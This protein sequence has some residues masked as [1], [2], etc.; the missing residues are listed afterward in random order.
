[1]KAV[2]HP[3]VGTLPDFGN[4][5]GDIDKYD[6]VEKMLPF[7]KGV[8][9][10]STKFEKNGN[11]ANIDY[12]RMMKLVADAGYEGYVGIE[13]SGPIESEYDGIKKTKKLL[14]KV[15]AEIRAQKK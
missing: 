15:T 10:K 2:N 13:Y 12:K 8:S 1:M 7:A 6:A 11:E 4:F 5:P 3:R 9:A 14:N